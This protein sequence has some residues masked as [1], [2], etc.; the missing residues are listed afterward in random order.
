VLKVG[1]KTPLSRYKGDLRRGD[2]M[3]IDAYQ[4]GRIVVDGTAYENDVIIAGNAVQ[5]NWWRKQG[6]LLSAEDIKPIIA[7]KPSVFVVGCGASRLMEVPSR[8][9]QVL[10]EHN[11]QL[12]ASDTYKAVKRFNELSQ[13]GVNVAAALHLTC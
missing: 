9:Q 13:A 7:A 8:T 12:E 4:F 1:Q 5:S 10:H 3:H 6:H 11:I 2:D